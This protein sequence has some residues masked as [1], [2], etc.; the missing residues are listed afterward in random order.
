MWVGRG[1]KEDVRSFFAAFGSLLRVLRSNSATPAAT[2]KLN[3]LVVPSKII[4]KNRLME[5]NKHGE[6][7]ETAPQKTIILFQ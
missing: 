1:R 6:I 5:G 3:L 2:A 7:N 4:K